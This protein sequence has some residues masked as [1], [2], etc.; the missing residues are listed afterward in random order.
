MID[1]YSADVYNEADEEQRLFCHSLLLDQRI[2]LCEPS[3]E[4]PGMAGAS[5][6]G[7]RSWIA[8]PLTD[9]RGSL[10]DDERLTKFGV[11]K[12]EPASV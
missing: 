10:S 12:P 3:T 9:I 8:V 1:L 2:V 11:R 5:L 6:P 7:S 4:L